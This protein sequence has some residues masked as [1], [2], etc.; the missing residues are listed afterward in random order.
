MVSE[1]ARCHRMTF[2][3]QNFLGGDP[4]NP[5]QREGSTPPTPSPFSALRASIF[6]T[7]KGVRIL[8]N[9]PATPLEAIR[10]YPEYSTS[11]QVP[12]PSTRVSIL[13]EYY[14]PNCSA[15]LGLRLQ[16]ITEP[17]FLGEKP[18]EFK[19]FRKNS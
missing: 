10:F 15:G 19:S 13:A 5:H 1:H 9:G 12:R 6:A 11:T 18:A 14:I 3:Y 4:P 7:G 16:N 8:K 2:T 17:L